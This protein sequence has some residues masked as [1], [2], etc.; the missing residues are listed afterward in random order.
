MSQSSK[1]ASGYHQRAYGSQDL[2]KLLDKL[3]AKFF[4]L[5][6]GSLVTRLEALGV[7]IKY[8]PV[9]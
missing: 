7:Q 1:R 3:N 6:C 9:K 8:G 2:W 4:A 5:G